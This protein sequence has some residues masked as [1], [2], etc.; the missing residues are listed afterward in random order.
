[1]S[2]C[3]L[4]TLSPNHPITQSTFT[5]L[6]NTA[7]KTYH[8]LL[9]LSRSPL[10]SSAL[11]EPAL[12]LDNVSPSP[13][14][15]GQAL[16]LVLRWAV[17]RLAPVRP[18]Y[19]LG[20]HRPLDDPTWRD[21]LWWRYNLLRHRYLEP[22]HPDDF[23]EGG[24]YT[25]TLMA[26]TGIPTQD[27]FFDERNRAVREIAAILWQ[28]FMEGQ[29][30][31]VL[32]S[33]ALTEALTPLERHPDLLALLGVASTFDQVFPRAL[34]LRMAT[35][36]ALPDPA[37]GLRGLIRRRLLLSS[38]DGEELWLSE[39]LQRAVYEQ[40][41]LELRNERQRRA[42]EHFLAAGDPIRAA[43]HLRRGHAYEQAAQ[44]LLG[45]REELLADLDLEALRTVLQVF[46][47]EEVQPA[48][49]LELQILLCDV[50]MRLG[51]QAEALA[52]CRAGIQ[53]AATNRDQAR[54]YRRMGKLYE[55]HNQLHA[56]GYYEQAVKGFPTTD[57]ELLDVLKDR[58]WLHI[59]RQEWDRA[60][61][62]LGFAL[63][64]TPDAAQS[65]QADI[66]DALASLHRRKGAYTVAVDYARRALTLRESLGDRLR[67][68]HS[69]GNL[70]LL[71]TAMEEYGNAIAAY[72]EAMA[73][74]QALGNRKSMAT[75][76]LN[77]GMAHH[78]A[79]RLED[80]VEAYN[81]SLQLCQAIGL[82]L[83]ETKVH[84][85]LVEALADLGDEE[86]ARRH[87][88]AGS[89]LSREHGFGDQVTYFMELRRRLSFLETIAAEPAVDVEEA[90]PLLMSPTL[91][92][93][94]SQVTALLRR[95]GRVTA[96]DL[97]SAAQISKATAT[98]RLTGLVERGVLRKQGR[99]R[100]VYYVAGPQMRA[101][102][103]TEAG[104]SADIV[105]HVQQIVRTHKVWLQAEYGVSNLGMLSPST[106][107]DPVVRLSI[108]FVQAPD[109]L[110]FFELERQLGQYIGQEIDLKLTSVLTD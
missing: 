101:W 19:P 16:R 41:P 100:G 46:G 24:R 55:E 61:A 70:G 14:E 47:E 22:I 99:G 76:L 23:V 83:V 74:F 45:A 49:W 15:R 89:R 106:E 42:A 31:E 25:E 95:T 12:V 93:V 20:V 30:N 92:P 9:A 109:L 29:A 51:R 94:D 5:Q 3:H 96:R 1:M 81:Q 88:I 18:T 77:M 7:F 33:L 69:L 28:Q 82:P 21:P 27:V 90:Q 17:S 64:H 26:L 84:S 58:A 60:E 53:V 97:M 38:K 4:V 6:V 34:L 40:Q 110:R 11:V 37:K 63:A 56:L 44:L 103:G 85:N 108:Q 62:D 8:S 87:W 67:V 73:T 105:T 80:A 72:R 65:Q 59:F 98:R 10:A 2:L 39:P 35:G 79:G 43:L 71:Y 36:E 57:P 86:A 75:A 32:R 91:D 48:T 13:E 54:L 52:A 102:A 66:C 104:A 107:G 50:C 68:A 78:L